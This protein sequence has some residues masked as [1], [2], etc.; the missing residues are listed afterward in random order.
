MIRYALKCIGDHRFEAWFSNSEAYDK[1][2]KRKL[3]ECPECGSHEVAKQIMAPAVRASRKTSA[4]R[5]G[6]EAMAAKVAGEIRNHIA[7]THDYVG[8]KFADEARSM[9]YGETDT[10]P[11]WGEVTPD[12]ARELHEEGVPALPLP[13]PFAPDKP[14]EP[15]KLN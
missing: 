7:T 5:P 11:V 12:V 13:K 3:V 15:G 9:F 4:A 10:R 6:P 2:R 8:D 14:R 1:Q